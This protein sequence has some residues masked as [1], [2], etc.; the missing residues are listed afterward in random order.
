MTASTLVL[1]LPEGDRKPE[2]H[3]KALKR[4]AHQENRTQ[5]T[6]K[7]YIHYNEEPYVCES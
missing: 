4:G 6:I 7:A 5:K 1:M 3:S 2:E